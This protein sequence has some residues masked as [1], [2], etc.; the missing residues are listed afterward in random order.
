MITKDTLERYVKEGWL[1]KQTHPTLPL[2]IYNYSQATQYAA[3]W[4]EVTLS[5]R[6]LIT[7]DETGEVIIKP[8]SKFFNYE[9][10]P[11][12]V[13]WESSE[14]V[15]VQDKMDGS[16]GILFNYKNQ[17]IMATRGSF[18]SEQ[19]IRGLEILKEKYILDT[20][21]PSV[22]YICEII[23]PE[24]RIVVDYGSKKKIVFLGVVLNR[25]WNWNAGGDDELHW[26]TACVYFKMSGIKKSDIVKTEQVFNGLGPDMY[27][28]LK[29]KNTDNSEGFVLRFHP[30]NTRVKIKFEDYVKLH[31]VLTNCS[32]YD[33]WENLKEFDKL[34]EEMLQD[35]PDEFYDWVHTVETSIR[36]NYD[37]ALHLHMA[38][39]SS[40]L[41]YGLD[42]KEFALRVQ[43]LKGVNHGLIFAMYNG[44]EDKM[45]QLIWKMIKPK[46]EKPFKTV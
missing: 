36:K 34:P 20:F 7:D 37:H 23:Y 16:L 31:R 24:N 9:E 6:G 4:D 29:S 3:K 40:M 25:S 44:K 30:S 8:F 35:V 32:S 46:Y 22:A 33:I 39:L 11:N 5:C 19:A 27:N 28:L 15:Y 14:Y 38:H 21:E 42:Q 18:M 17:W 41:R 13:P 12:E 45:K 10:V 1:I 26:T 2:S 43:D